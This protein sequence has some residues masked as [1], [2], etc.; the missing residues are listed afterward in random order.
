MVSSGL[1]RSSATTSKSRSAF[2]S[3][4]HLVKAKHPDGSSPRPSP[5][6]RSARYCRRVTAITNLSDGR[7]AHRRT[8]RIRQPPADD[9]EAVVGVRDEGPISR[10]LAV[11]AVREAA[12]GWLQR[13][14]TQV[15][16]P[17][18][19]ARAVCPCSVAAGC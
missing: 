17:T 3:A 8:P 12:Q 6:P 1:I 7:R 9:S 16:K 19:R 15:A 2:P 18:R 4:A 10:Y 13:A 5:R 14:L 11:K